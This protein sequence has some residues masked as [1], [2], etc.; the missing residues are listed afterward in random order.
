[1]D[2]KCIE[3]AGYDDISK[4]TIHYKA[5]YGSKSKKQKTYKIIKDLLI[6]KV[7]HC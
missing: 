1:M 7:N 3:M 6:F 5:V 2:V 4:I